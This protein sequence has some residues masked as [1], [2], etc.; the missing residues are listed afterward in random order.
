MPAIALQDK[1]NA[2]FVQHLHV[3]PPSPDMDLIE[4]G[5]IDSLTLVELIARLEQEFSIRI[6]LA[7]VDL[8]HF[9]SI[10]RIDQFVQMKLSQSE[11]ALGSYSGV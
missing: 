11:E 10:D 1:I 2:V 5:M 3:Q 6:P 7:D 9:R 4:N 8:N